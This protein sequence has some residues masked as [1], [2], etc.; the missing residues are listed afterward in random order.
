MVL[1][2]VLISS[3]NPFCGQGEGEVLYKKLYYLFSC[4]HTSDETPHGSVIFNS[5]QTIFRPVVSPAFLSLLCKVH[6]TSIPL[7]QELLIGIS[8]S[9]SIKLRLREGSGLVS[10]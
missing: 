4:N 7:L 9:Q 8:I 2:Y 10:Y 1:G 5:L 6:R 3:T